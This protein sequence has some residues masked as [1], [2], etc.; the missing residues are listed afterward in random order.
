MEKITNN[1]EKFQK[2]IKKAISK[3]VKYLLKYRLSV[4]EEEREKK[5]YDGGATILMTY[6]QGHYGVDLQFNKV[7]NNL[8]KCAQ[9]YMLDHKKPIFGKNNKYNDLFDTNFLRD[10]Y[11]QKYN[12]YPLDVYM[13]IYEGHNQKNKLKN[14]YDI[15]SEI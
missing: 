15:S 12:Q 14:I 8:V 2:G 4:I 6:M 13:V 11:L 5:T 3:G 9:N 10:I 7:Y 1:D